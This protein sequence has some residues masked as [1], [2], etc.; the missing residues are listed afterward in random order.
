MQTHCKMMSFNRDYTINYKHL[1]TDSNFKAS[2]TQQNVCKQGGPT[3]SH[4]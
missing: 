3:M 2:Q 1:F 4:S